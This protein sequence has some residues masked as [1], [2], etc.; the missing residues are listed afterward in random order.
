MKYGN[1]EGTKFFKFGLAMPMFFIE[2]K[3]AKA[4]T[5]LGF[6]IIACFLLP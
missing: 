6:L 5:L 3:R 2:T 1:P 4:L